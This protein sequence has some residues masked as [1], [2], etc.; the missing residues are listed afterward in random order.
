MLTEDAAHEDKICIQTSPSTQT[1]HQRPFFSNTDS[2]D[3]PFNMSHHDTRATG[4]PTVSNPT[5]ELI[6]QTAQGHFRC[7][8]P[9]DD[10][11][12]P[13]GQTVPMPCLTLIL[14]AASVNIFEAPCTS[15]QWTKED[16]TWLS[17]L[18]QQFTSQIQLEVVWLTLRAKN[19][20]THTKVV[21]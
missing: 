6:S 14:K 12:G 15:L 1:L 21:L 20:P 17:P 13:Y 10:I 19:R 5:L 4:L 11:K 3:S 18:L 8:Q 2:E 9:K 7:K 16:T